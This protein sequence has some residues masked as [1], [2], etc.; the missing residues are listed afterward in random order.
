ME[1]E[2]FDFDEDS[3]VQ[4]MSL[5]PPQLHHQFTETSENTRVYHQEMTTT[6]SE[7]FPNPHNLLLD[8]TGENEERY[9]YISTSNMSNSHGSSG[10]SNSTYETASTSFSI[11][12]QSASLPSSSPIIALTSWLG[13]RGI[14]NNESKVQPSIE[15]ARQFKSSSMSEISISSQ[16]STDNKERGSG[17]LPITLNPK[18]LFEIN[19]PGMEEEQSVTGAKT[20]LDFIAIILANT[21]L[22]QSKSSQYVES[23]LEAVPLYADLD[24][25][26]VF[27]GICLGR[28]MKFLEKQL[29]QVDEDEERKFDKSIWSANIGALCWIIVDHVY[30]GAFPKPFDVLETLEFL[31]SMLAASNKDGSV[32]KVIPSGK[33]LL[34]IARGGRQQGAYVHALLKCVN[35]MIMYCFLPSFLTTIDEVD[36]LLHLGFQPKSM[37]ILLPRTSHD[38]SPID[39][40]SVL[41]IVLSH[42]QL[43]FCPN[44]LDTTLVCCF[45]INLITLLKDPRQTACSLAM[46][47]MKYLLLHRKNTLEELLASKSNQGQHLNVLHGGFDKL[48]TETSGT[49]LEWLQKSEEFVNIVLDQSAA[50]IW[51]QYIVGSEKFPSNRIKVMENRR[52]RELE[53]KY[54][55]NLKLD[56]RRL[57]H[58]SAR[59]NDFKFDRESMS[60]ELRIIHQ[61]KYSWVL[62]AESEWQAHVQQLFHERGIIPIKSSLPDPAWQLC[63]IEG[64]Y[65]MR[66]RLER[67]RLKNETIQSYLIGDLNLKENNNLSHTNLTNFDSFTD[68]VLNHSS[69]GVDENVFSGADRHKD[70]E[71]TY[72]PTEWNEDSGNINEENLPSAMVSIDLS[73]TL[74]DEKY[75]DSPRMSPPSK[76][77]HVKDV[78]E[79]ENELHDNGEYLIRPYLQPDERIRFKYNC[80]RVLSLDKHDGIFLIGEQCLYVIDNF[81]VDDSGCICEKNN[82][83]ELSVIDQALGVERNV[84]GFS[85]VDSKIKP[86]IGSGRAWACNGGTWGKN[87]MDV[88]GILHH[89]WHMWKLSNVSELLKRDYQLRHVAIEIFSTDGRNDLLVFHRKE[90]EEVFK[91]ITSTN[92][93]KNNMCG[94]SNFLFISFSLFC[95]I[96][97]VTKITSLMVSWSYYIY[98]GI[99]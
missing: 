10:K 76:T 92:I 3:N 65:R 94:F 96:N 75:L 71:S 54:R 37:N 9:D 28:L 40:C 5:C 16:K 39:I 12:N 20:I 34:S 30:M 55:D 7:D 68:S 84:N 38:D 93:P 33:G 11:G 36:F 43:I 98:K 56:S 2:E 51:G 85:D 19:A 69:D 82:D 66:K 44:N 47:M 21:V 87:N 53:R 8:N 49:F 57:E 26:L 35:R 95:L 46:D 60:K 59:W 77:D 67:S 74:V 58:I 78:G 64:P 79:L 4:H 88:C 52:K 63:P 90:R 50:L 1:N 97:L 15:H 41:R 45:C 62:H 72:S 29:V 24:S 14:D 73:D 27:Q 48:L 13:S 89:P 31:L 17:Y 91:N 61:K 42:K 70:E 81:Y 25:A 80:E 32:E 99:I 18:L 86:L 23:I 83:D 22:K 6:I